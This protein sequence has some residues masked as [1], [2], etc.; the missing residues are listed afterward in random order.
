MIALL[1]V[2]AAFTACSDE[3]YWDEAPV[4]SEAVYS[5]EQ[6]TQTISVEASDPMNEIVVPIRR[7]TS[8]GEVTVDI[9]AEFSSDVMSGPSQVVF[10]DGSNVANYVIS[11]GETEVAV[12][13]QAKLS[14]V[15]A[16]VTSISGN[17]SI[18][19]TLTKNF[20][21]QSLGKGKFM[22]NFAGD[23]QTMYDVE[24]EQA[25]GFDR[26]RLIQPY[27]ELLATDAGEWGDWIA[28][29]T[30]TQYL[31]FYKEGDGWT[32]DPYMLGIN[33]EGVA[34]QGIAAYPGSYFKGCDDSFNKQLA[35]KVFQLAPYYYVD[36]VGGWN[37]TAYDGVILIQLP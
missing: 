5:F 4:N 9:K 11:V 13:Y 27:K 8:N 15:D 31:T 29:K 19:I 6:A 30:Q 16:N 33:Y 26:Y 10:A 7:A 34:S 24:I 2:T 20:T 22:D 3:G 12:K 28:A 35:E 25:V 37:R 32:F 21:W 1:A 36:G 23:G 14:F 17:S 18:T